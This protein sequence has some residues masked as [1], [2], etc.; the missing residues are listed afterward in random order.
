MNKD[1]MEKLI[2]DY[3]IENKENHYRLAYS[4]VKNV[5]NALDIVQESILKAFSSIDSLK[6]SDYIKTW[7][8]RIIVNTSLDF[9]RKQKRIVLDEEIISQYD[10]GVIDEYQDIDLK[11]A[12]DELPDKYRNVIVLRYFEDLK[13]EEIAEILEENISTIKTRLYTALKKLHIKMSP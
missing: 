9:L 10:S 5:D 6:S 7:F 8:Y 2:A 4:Y 11:E 12:L 3:I 13:I 1:R